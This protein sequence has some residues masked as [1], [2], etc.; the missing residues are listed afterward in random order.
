MMPFYTFISKAELHSFNFPSTQNLQ[1]EILEGVRV[2]MILQ[3]PIIKSNFTPNCISRSLSSSA[4]STSFLAW[5]GGSWTWCNVLK[6]TTKI[7]KLN[8]NNV[9]KIET[10]TTFKVSGRS[11]TNMWRLKKEVEV[12]ERFQ[13]NTAEKTK[14]WVS[15]L[16]WRCRKKTR[17]LSIKEEEWKE[18]RVQ[19]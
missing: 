4:N 7:Y 12:V 16:V 19:L 18:R 10:E 8:L 5:R 14:N 1:A 2:T 9:F 17:T 11:P 15:G 3:S 13:S 6:V